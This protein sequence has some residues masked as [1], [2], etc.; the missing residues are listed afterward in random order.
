MVAARLRTI[1]WL[2]VLGWP[3][4]AAAAPVHVDAVIDEHTVALGQHLVLDVNARGSGA[5]LADISLAPL[6]HDFGV[7]V[8]Q[9]STASNARSAAAQNLVLW[10]YPRHLGELVVPS[11]HLAGAVT[12]PL[13]VRV[14][15]AA[16]PGGVMTF[17]ALPTAH[18]VWTR[19]QLLMRVQIETPESFA[20]VEPQMAEVPGFNLVPLPVTTRHPR[21]RPDR[22]IYETGWALFPHTAGTTA[23]SLPAVHYLRNGIVQRVFYPPTFVLHVHP[24]PP[25]IPPTMPVGTVGLSMSLS[26]S[27][28]LNTTSPAELTLTLYGDGIPFTSLPHVLRQFTGRT[29]IHF[30][31]AEIHHANHLKIS[32]VYGETRYRIPL[33]PTTSGFLHLPPVRF[34]TFNPAS[35]RIVTSRYSSPAAV[36]VGPWWRLAGAVVA[37]GLLAYLLPRALQYV[38]TFLRRWRA[39]RRAI[40]QLR[41]ADSPDALYVALRALAHAEGQ[42]HRFTLCNWLACRAFGPDTATAL[43][44]P[45][46]Q[47]Q[48]HRYGR[49]PLTDFVKVK[50]TILRHVN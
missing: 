6:K 39:R 12:A 26:P 42:N 5:N 14:T 46:Q 44:T 29:D 33:R 7:V 19:Q 22:T 34:E 48:R 21:G 50:S 4:V 24:L 31:P 38:L 40:A 3:V 30:L 1:R 23:V 45:I 25:Y 37:F 13:S 28:L 36:A 18:T 41:H 2:F 47:L 15:A 49:A 10:L 17:S 43:K 8:I 20:D 32:G 9:S 16:V 35:G 27:T 11:L